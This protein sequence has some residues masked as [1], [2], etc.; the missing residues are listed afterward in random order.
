MLFE[1]RQRGAEADPAV[2]AALAQALGVTPVL[3]GLLASRGVTT[4][5]EARR[6]FAAGAETLRDPLGLAGMGQAVERVRLALAAG[7]PI[8][9][10]GDYDV[11]GVCA[12]SILVSYLREQGGDVAFYIPSR[13]TEGYGLNRAAI[14]TLTDRK[15]LI[16]VDCGVS[17]R[18]EVAH[19]RSLGMDVIVT[20]HHE[21]PEELPDCTAV[22]NPKR[23]GQD[24]G[25]SGLCGAGV[26]FQLVRALGGLEAALA[27]VDL[28]ALATV[29]D[30]VP[31]VD[32]NR[33]LVRLGL[34]SMNAAPRPGVA[35]LMEVAGLNGR[36]LKAG[37]IA[38]GLAPRINAGG[39]MDYSRKSVEMMLTDDAEAAR[40][41]AQELD[42]DNRDRLAVEDAMLRE[43]VDMV[44]RDYDFAGRRAIVLCQ[45][46]WNTG[47]TGIVAARLVERYS[48]PTILFGA[49]EGACYGSG[50]SVPGVHLYRA[51]LAC[52]RFFLRFGGHEQAAGCAL[53]EE[54]LD[55]FRDALDEHLRGACPQEV[56]LP[57]RAYDRDL[58]LTEV[59]LALARELEQM[60]PTG[61]GNPKPVFLLRQAPLSGLS[62]TRDGKHLRMRF[63]GGD[64]LEGIAFRQGDSFDM[65]NRSPA[66]DALVVPDVNEFRGVQRVQA[67]V[68]HLRPPQ[69][70]AFAR[71]VV[72]GAGAAVQRALCAGGDDVPAAGAACVP[73]Q[74][75]MGELI[76]ALQESPW[77]TLVL[78]RTQSSAAAVLDG[79]AAAGCLGRVYVGEGI[80]PQ[81]RRRENAIVLAPDV[82]RLPLHQFGRI[83]LPDGPLALPLAGQLNNDGRCIIMNDNHKSGRLAELFCREGLLDVYRRMQTALR[84]G[85]GP[86]GPADWD[87]L[88][89]EGPTGWAA[90]V[91]ARVFQELGL[92]AALDRAPWLAVP[93]RGERTDLL[94]SA[95]YRRVTACL[96]EV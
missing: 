76:A 89:A 15:L 20:D 51:L 35:A 70:E 91:A 11:D 81:A 36:P 19:A 25:F 95:I 43:A 57:S 2:T 53:V 94:L 46:H 80:A 96:T 33:A 16:T 78:C 55:A 83:Y 13:H 63:G 72:A 29:A 50:R 90:E 37:N 82:T 28:A 67:Q 30:L 5:E 86:D 47:V 61:F 69:D 48:R 66:C 24:Y 34:A 38:F 92:L 64:G 93:P 21:C 4:E 44:E 7:E 1:Y 49:G 42:D 6:F 58:E 14:E 27:R 88:G 26:A 3:A 12:T 17:N 56:F 65:L 60:E 40:A 52:S 41:T 73:W 85:K 77:G 39:R 32:E 75:G 45:P 10:Y 22:I 68:E 31:L 71:A 59:G 54:N 74:Q 87:W 84:A 62:R 79:L 8:V 9:V 18:E 23:P